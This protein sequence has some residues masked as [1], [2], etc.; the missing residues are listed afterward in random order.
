MATPVRPVN[1]LSIMALK[2]KDNTFDLGSW[3]RHISVRD[4]IIR[5]RLLVRDLCE[6]SQLIDGDKILV[7]GA[8]AAGLAAAY[9]L[10]EQGVQVL[11]VDRSPEPFSLWDQV[12]QRF[13]GP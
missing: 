9:A 8:G 4:Q 5:A 13:V 10:L 11:V 6:S 3:L 7:I 1:P 2:V 12:T